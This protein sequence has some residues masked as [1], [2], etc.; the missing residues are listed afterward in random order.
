MALV[1]TV[2]QNASLDNDYGTTRGPNALASH[3]LALY[4]GDP[5]E[6]GVEISGNGYARVTIAAADWAAAADGYKSLS[7]AVTF[8]APTDE[9]PLTVRY[10]AL[11]GA[12][13]IWDSGPFAEEIDVTAAAPA[14][15]E[16]SISIFYN[17]AVPDPT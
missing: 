16:V 4:D 14:G 3:D 15:P 2:A 7:A 17:D 6:E 13:S 12:G 8:P 9:W 5:R 1:S 10:W 11:I